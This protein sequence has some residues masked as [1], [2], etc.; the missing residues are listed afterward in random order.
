MSKLGVFRAPSAYG[1]RRHGTVDQISSADRVV[2]FLNT[3]LLMDIAFLPANSNVRPWTTTAVRCPCP[4]RSA[5]ARTE[6]A[7]G[8]FCST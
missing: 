1:Y 2:L 5:G 6:A 4:S 8:P 3:V 7:N